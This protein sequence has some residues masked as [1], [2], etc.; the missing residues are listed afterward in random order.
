M[1]EKPIRFGTG[2]WR[3]VIGSDFIESNIRRTAE[4][5][6]ALMCEEGRT[7]KP[8]IIGYDHRFLSETAARWIAEVLAAHGVPVMFLRRSAPTPLIM[9]T[10]LRQGLHYGIE[11]TASH[12]PSCYNGVKLIVEEGRD[13]P[14]ETTA[15]LE[16]LIAAVRPED[17]RDMPFE[18]AEAAGLIL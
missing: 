12:N 2:G 1:Q 18:D 17:V 16:Q 5:I 6:C 14:V 9:H 4:G 3:A 10:V 8:V 13:A 11:I 15:R 7:D